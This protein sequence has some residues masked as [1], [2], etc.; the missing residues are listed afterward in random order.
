MKGM[1][2]VALLLALLLMAGC[3]NSTVIQGDMD[4]VED[5]VVVEETLSAFDKFF[6]QETQ[7]EMEYPYDYTDA[8]FFTMKNCYEYAPQ[9]TAVGLVDGHPWYYPQ[10]EGFR[11]SQGACSDGE[12]GYFSMVKADAVQVGDVYH[13]AVRIYKVDMET[14]EVVE[15][16][17]DIF[18]QHSNSMCYNANLD[19][20]V[21]AF[22]G[23]D[24][25]KLGIVDADTLLLENVVEI[26][27][28]ASCITYNASRDQYVIWKTG[29]FDMAI[30]DGDFKV[31]KE[32]PGVDSLLG[33][34]NIHCDDERIYMLSS[35]CVQD[36]G[37]EAIMCYDW[38]GN[39]IGVY[40]IVVQEFDGSISKN[41]GETETLL[42]HNGEF[43]VDFNTRDGLNVYKLEIDFDELIW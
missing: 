31:V 21:I 17:G 27:L 8:S 32:I 22:C 40:R 28:E 12:Y 25:N 33:L 19:K 35:G 23:P 41:V 42:I 10:D 43:Y 15:K 24:A 30:L 37:K 39:Y 29:W 9:A 6:L 4:A 1:K 18:T 2:L 16:S 36:P 11:V 34:Q 13:D 26:S 20:I 3:G 14:L 5:D 7:M 38:D